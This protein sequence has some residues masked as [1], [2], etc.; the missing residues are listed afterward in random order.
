[1]RLT[2]INATE[3]L[4]GRALSATRVADLL[5][6]SALHGG[7][8]YVGM[9]NN[10]VD[11]AMRQSGAQSAGVSLSYRYNNSELAWARARGALQD[12]EG[13]RFPRRHSPCGAS[14]DANATQLF[15]RPHRYF[16]WIYLAGIHI[17][18][19]LVTPIVGPHARK[20]GTLWMITHSDDSHLFNQND[21]RALEQASAKISGAISDSLYRASCTR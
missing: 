19:M 11:G 9:L 6:G 21:A 3:H 1:M 12:F 5:D 17:A 2:D 4:A 8:H 7:C 16:Q 13:R 10:F 20:F 14:L 15:I 18:E